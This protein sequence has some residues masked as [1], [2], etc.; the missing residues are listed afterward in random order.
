MDQHVV[1]TTTQN[2]TDNGNKK[3]NLYFLQMFVS[4]LSELKVRS[5]IWNTGSNIEHNRLAASRSLSLELGCWYN[6]EIW[7]ALRPRILGRSENSGPTTSHDWRGNAIFVRGIRWS[8][9]NSFHKKPVME[10]WCFIVVNLN[11][12]LNKR[13]ICWWFETTWRPC[14]NSTLAQVMPCCLTAPSHYL[15][16]CN[17]KG[18][19]LSPHTRDHGSHCPR[20]CLVPRGHPRLHP[21]PPDRQRHLP[22]SWKRGPALK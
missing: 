9:I 17:V 5:K 15:N 20:E 18:A 2:S 7:Q 12:L 8:Q 3:I 13:S 22:T 6:F 10:L 11:E 4:S 16:Q 19:S 14:E 1:T 21:T